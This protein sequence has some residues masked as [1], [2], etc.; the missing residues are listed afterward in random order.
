VEGGDQAGAG[1]SWPA[2]GGQAPAAP[3]GQDFREDGPGEGGPAGPA[4]QAQSADEQGAVV[5]AAQLVQRGQRRAEVAP[6][7]EQD[8]WYGCDEREQGGEGAQAKQEPAGA[9]G[10]P[11]RV[12]HGLLLPRP[13]VQ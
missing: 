7:N 10:G 5:G 8:R 11:G 9:A 1:A 6:G 3:L 12:A 2:E 4:D 13:R